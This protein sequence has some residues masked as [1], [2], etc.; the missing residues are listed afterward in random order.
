MSATSLVVAMGL[1]VFGCTLA[2]HAR[3]EERLSPDAFELIRA[4]GLFIDLR[5]ASERRQQGSPRGSIS[6]PYGFPDSFVAR[7]EAAAGHDRA[8]AIVLIC[9]AGTNSR[10]AADLLASRGFTNVTSVSD[11]FGG[12]SHGPGWKAWGLPVE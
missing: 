9:R 12:S 7:V 8:A 5:E 4:P 1:P 11:G 3:Y 2:D 10:M 6:I